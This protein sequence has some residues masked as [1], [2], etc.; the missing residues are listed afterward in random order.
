MT[1]NLGAL[2]N[3]VVHR[4]LRSLCTALSS[5]DL[6]ATIGAMEK[7]DSGSGRLL[8]DLVANIYTSS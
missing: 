3:V 2:G 4:K 8:N 6:V 7:L 5:S 1:E